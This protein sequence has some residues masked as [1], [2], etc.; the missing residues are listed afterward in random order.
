MIQ[1][2]QQ[3]SRGQQ[4][5]P[6][7]PPGGGQ[8]TGPHADTGRALRNHDH[9][10]PGGRGGQGNVMT[11]HHN[12]II[13]SCHQVESPAGGDDTRSWGPPFIEAEQGTRE[14]CYF[15]S[16]NRNKKV[17]CQ[18]TELLQIITMVVFIEHLC[19][20]EEEGGPENPAAARPA[21]RRHD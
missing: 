3:C 4:R 1:G 21:E 14:S 7:E 13:M 20:Y 8:D 18:D 10:R 12:I 9:V 16:V 5:G 6:G 15:L 17:T 2:L 19:E 11:C